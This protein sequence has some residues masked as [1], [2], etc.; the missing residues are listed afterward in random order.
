[1][2][3]DV[4]LRR[5]PHRMYWED[6]PSQEMQRLFVQVAHIVF[7]D[8]G[9]KLALEQGFYQQV[10]DALAREVGAGSLLAANTYD[11]ICGRLLMEDYDLW[12]NRQ[13][14]ADDF[15]KLRL[16]LIELLF[17]ALQDRVTEAPARE[18]SRS[19]LAR[20]LA[21]ST[22]SADQAREAVSVA[23]RELNERLRQAQ[24]GLH[25]HN[26]MLQF[27]QDDLTQDVNAEPCWSL[28]TDSKWMNVDRDL[29]EAFDRADTG[30]ADA[31]FYAA[32]ALESTIKIISDDKGWT[33]GS[34]KGAA[35][36][37]DNLVSQKNGRFI[38]TWEGDFL[39]GYFT[40]IRNPHGHGAGSQPPPALADYQTA[41][42]IET[43]MSWIKSLIRRL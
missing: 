28:L 30:R 35:N 7:K 24:I 32:K 1:M 8:L 42:A 14:S 43:A 29:K 11:E 36:Y 31:A 20:A 10:H 40:H 34:E 38:S 5:Y 25:F 4:F 21:P 22:T 37:I 17:R 39:R 9:P 23:V 18:P 3:H 16:S 6:A 27:S 19:F 13:G 15:I 12:S 2:I 33:T 26:G 41:W